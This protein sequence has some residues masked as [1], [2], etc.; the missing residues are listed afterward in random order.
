ML[1]NPSTLVT[2]QR[3]DVMTKISYVRSILTGNT[4][5]FSRLLYRQYLLKSNGGE[6]FE[7]GGKKS[8]GDYEVAFW[9]LVSSLR[10]NGYSGPPIPVTRNGISNGAHRLAACL[11]MGIDIPKENVSDADHIY[12]YKFMRRIGLSEELI[13]STVRE[14]L[15]FDDRTRAFLLTDFKDDETRT[16]LELLGNKAQIVFSGRWSMSQIGIRRVMDLAYGHLPW[17]DSSK[18]ET[19][20]AERYGK[21]RRDYPVGLVL[22]VPGSNV[23]D[24]Q[25]LKANLRA[26]FV[27]SRFDRNIHGSDTIEETERLAVT[28]LSRPGR[29]FLNNS[30]IGSELPILSAVTA[31]TK[32]ISGTSVSGSFILSLYSDYQPSDL[33]LIHSQDFASNDGFEHGQSYLNTPFRPSEIIGDPRRTFEYKGITF[34]SLGTWAAHRVDNFEHKASSQLEHLSRLS[35]HDSDPTIYAQRAAVVRAARYR[36]TKKLADMLSPLAAWI[37]RPLLTAFRRIMNELLK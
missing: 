13:E 17:W 18:Y 30:P 31:P 25:S 19:T 8:I 14:Y 37:P 7:E 4:S 24:I 1:C 29:F 16:F 15:R 20:V 2:P 26:S 35:V 34:I 11:V 23:E 28:L 3:L 6:A 10:K 9:N 36:R 5:D 12:D 32:D 33:D 22:Y 21:L 27:G